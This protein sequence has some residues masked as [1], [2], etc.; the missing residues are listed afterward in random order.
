MVTYPPA[1]GPSRRTAVTGVALTVA[2]LIAGLLWAKWVP[3]VGKAL[4]AART[5]EWSGK[6]ILG[7][8]GVRA[9][10]APSWSAATSFFG[11]YALAIW[12]ALLVAILVSACVQAFVPRTWLPR[13][14]NRRHLLSTAAAG[15]L[16]SM[17]TMMCTCCA[18]PVAV[19]MRR[20]GV[21]RAAVVAYWLGNPLLNPAVLVFLLFVAPWQWS[22]TRLLVGGLAVIGAAVLVGLLTRRSEAEP[23]PAMAADLAT[24]D[25]TRS[26]PARFIA[27]L[28]RMSVVLLP[29]YLIVVLLIGACRGWLLELIQPAHQGLLVVLVAAVLGTLLVIPTAGEIPILQGMALL[30]LSSGV[31]GALLIT[32][33]AV[34]FPGI[35]MVVRSLGWK[36]V[37]VTAGTI[38]VAGLAGGAVLTLL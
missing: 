15:G 8:G 9:G 30:G 28:V 27:A 14:L 4:A 7:V 20:T 29:E 12:P 36:T 19:T 16:A 3:Y 33:P 35:A 23:P 6:D 1:A 21:S 26:A 34:S 38:V 24:Q 32:L 5:H 22:F 25:E 10:D 17:P 18:A 37:G 2:V 11:T 31:L 13:L